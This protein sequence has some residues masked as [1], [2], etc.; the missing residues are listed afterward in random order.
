MTLIKLLKS[1][2][3]DIEVMIMNDDYILT[4]IDFWV[5]AINMQLPIILFHGESSL[6]FTKDLKWLCMSGTPETDKFY[7]IRMISNN[8]YNLITPPSMLRDLNGFQQMIES[9][10]YT[11]HF[12]TFDD[13]ITE[14]EIIVPKLKIRKPRKKKA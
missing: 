14:Y 10:T 5:L 11:D 6:P 7:F 12:I 3:I 13:Y 4:A 2:Q 8:Q 1:Q 9:P